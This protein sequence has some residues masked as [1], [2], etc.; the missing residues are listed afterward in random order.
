M[1]TEYV[2]IEQDIIY[3]RRMQNSQRYSEI[4]EQ[5]RAGLAAQLSVLE[6]QWDAKKKELNS[7]LYRLI[8]ADFWPVASPPAGL[9]PAE[10]KFRDL[11]V[12]VWELRDN[13]QELYRLV[14]TRSE[15]ARS[16]TPVTVSSVTVTND[17]PP[18]K[19]RRLTEDESQKQE[20]STPQVPDI[21]SAPP[22]STSPVQSVIPP[23]E[24]DHIRERYDD[25][26]H[27]INNLENDMVQ[28]DNDLLMQVEEHMESKFAALHLQPSTSSEGSLDTGQ[29]LAEKLQLLQHDI[30]SVGDDMS[31]LVGEVA[32]L[33]TSSEEMGKEIQA[34]KEEKESMQTRI[35]TVCYIH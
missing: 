10:D 3:F 12:T 18:A 14:Q 26:E 22:Q 15:A 21:A 4:S 9:T 32:S 31:A 11:R 29:A 2:K 33:I 25:L 17:Q 30:D 23:Q 27:R 35:T 6:S 24:L 28:Y 20:K 1:R 5:S 7:A 19:R 16:L 8:D 13:V 34:L